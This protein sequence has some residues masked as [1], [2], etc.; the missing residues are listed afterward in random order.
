MLG[1]E[2]LLNNW[3]LYQ[4]ILFVLNK[5]QSGLSFTI[6]DYNKI[7][8]IVQQQFY[9]DERDQYE[10]TQVVTNAIE[11]MKKISVP[12]L[13]INSDGVATLPGDYYYWGGCAYI[14]TINGIPQYN[15]V[16]RLTD[17]E[18]YDRLGSSIDGP[19]ED[20]P[21][22]LIRNGH[23]YFEPLRSKYVKFNYLK[24]PTKPFIDYYQ[25]ENYNEIYKVAG[26]IAILLFKGDTYNQI[27]SVLLTGINS[28]NSDDGILYWSFLYNNSTSLYDLSIYKDSA[29]NQLVS[30]GSVSVSGAITL[31]EID[32]SG[33]SGT[34]TVVIQPYLTINGNDYNKISNLKLA[35]I[36][37]YKTLYW[38]LVYISNYSTFLI[39]SD[40]LK[41]NLLASGT[42]PINITSGNITISGS[43]I[44]GSVSVVNVLENTIIG[45]TLGAL[46]S[47][48]LLNT[49]YNRVFLYYKLA[50]DLTTSK[51]SFEIY[52]DYALTTKLSSG[53]INGLGTNIPLV[54]YNG[55]GY[56]G[57]IVASVIKTGDIHNQI[58][59]IRLFGITASNSDNGVLY[60]KS[61]LVSSTHTI[62]FYSDSAK[63]HLV[64]HWNGTIGSS[65]SFD[66]ASG[67]T[68]SINVVYWGDDNASNNTVNVNVTEIHAP[69]NEC[70]ITYGNGDISDNNSIDVI[71]E[72]GPENIIIDIPASTTVEMEWREEDQVRIAGRALEV[73]GINL[74]DNSIIQYAQQYKRPA[75]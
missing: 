26:A 50:Y 64:A 66:N 12:D 71:A 63:T 19:T 61:L 13:N 43:G 14:S 53:S 75:R 59:S 65:L 48:N 21:F 57:N 29:K 28:N 2:N 69:G 39:Y 56:S 67:I 24:Y 17:E 32:S 55:S 31:Y 25:D 68:G 73:I 23:I 11:R 54:Q 33:I 62:N 7:I 6:P 4:F 46:S 35:N 42:L 60:W 10:R 45:D 41:T 18:Y 37:S 34:G 72:D 3:D 16:A 20:Y 5:D 22:C 27:T 49:V 36:S 52:S 70:Y 15:S 74:K 9:D 58:R 38:K 44:T 47:F 40:Y 51:T 30:K 8:P 1:L